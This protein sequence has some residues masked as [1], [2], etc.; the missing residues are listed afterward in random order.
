MRL[1][2]GVLFFFKAF[3]DDGY[4]LVLSHDLLFLVFRYLETVGMLFVG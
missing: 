2:R 4:F 1:A 3:L